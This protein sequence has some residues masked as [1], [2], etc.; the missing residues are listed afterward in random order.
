[1]FYQAKAVYT[2]LTIA[3]GIHICMYFGLG[4][5][6]NQV[7]CIKDEANHSETKYLEFKI[8]QKT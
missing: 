5:D 2:L 4:L 1:M 3:I 8:C 6:T 7:I